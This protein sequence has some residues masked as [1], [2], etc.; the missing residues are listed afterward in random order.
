MRLGFHYHIPALAVPEG[1]RVP[2]PL[3]VFLDS[4]AAPLSA[5]VHYGKRQQD[6]R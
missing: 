5:S 4:L 6:I 3:G 2:G 1:F